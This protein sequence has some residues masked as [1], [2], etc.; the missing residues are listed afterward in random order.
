M[1]EKIGHCEFFF[2]ACGHTLFIGYRSSQVERK[3]KNLCQVLVAAIKIGYTSEFRIFV[4]FSKQ[5]PIYRNFIS[6]M[7]FN[8]LFQRSRNGSKEQKGI[9]ENEVF[10]NGLEQ[11]QFYQ[12]ENGIRIAVPTERLI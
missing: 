1:F 4:C 6:L 7:N 2:R 10:G 11:G 8:H 12:I 9:L 5:I 3:N